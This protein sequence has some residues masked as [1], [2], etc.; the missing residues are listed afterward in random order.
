MGQRCTALLLGVPMGDLLEQLV[1]DMDEL[2]W[3]DT[4]RTGGKRLA[5]TPETGEGLVC[6]GYVFACGHPEDGEGDLA[7]NLVPVRKIG[8]AFPKQLVLARSRWDR[9]AKWV[10]LEMGLDLPDPEIFI[11][12]VE[13]G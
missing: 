3:D 8:E 6:I 7:E 4:P 1:G 9:L 5:E 10:K 13:R 11:M 2:I 12:P